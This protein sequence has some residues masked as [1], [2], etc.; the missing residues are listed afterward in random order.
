MRNAKDIKRHHGNI[1]SSGSCAPL[2]TEKYEGGC[3]TLLYRGSL[4]QR[5]S[6]TKE[7][8]PLLISSSRLNL[9]VCK[10]RMSTSFCLSA[11][12]SRGLSV[13]Y[14][15]SHPLPH[16]TSYLYLPVDFSWNL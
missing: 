3:F 14:D 2:D 6:G 8:L 13:D 11:G 7:M 15:A 10:S 4:H 5:L 9:S 1:N 12:G 16:Q